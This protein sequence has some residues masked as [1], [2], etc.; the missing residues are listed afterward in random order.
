M[1]ASKETTAVVRAHLAVALVPALNDAL[2]A[3]CVQEP[4]LWREQD[5]LP[6][7]CSAYWDLLLESEWSGLRR[8]HVN[9]GAL[10]ELG[11]RWELVR[12]GH[13]AE[14][15]PPYLCSGSAARCH[16]N[17]APLLEPAPGAVPW[18]LPF[19]VLGVL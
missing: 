6:V 2:A 14:H 4:A 8:A 9:A 15:V 12:P 18:Q 7:A 10:R 17:L 1:G 13:I 16:R 5:A 3:L 19:A 11:L